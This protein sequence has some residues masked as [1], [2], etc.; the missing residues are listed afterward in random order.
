MDHDIP[1]QMVTYHTLLID[2]EHKE[3]QLANA[4]ERQV[5]TSPNYSCLLQWVGKWANKIL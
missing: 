5:L 4:R 2:H 3:L 1:D